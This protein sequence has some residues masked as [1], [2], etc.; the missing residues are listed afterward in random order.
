VITRLTSADVFPPGTYP[1][2]GGG[3]VL[4]RDGAPHSHDFI[5]LAIVLG[6]SAIHVTDGRQTE[7]GAGSIVAVRPGGW[8]GYRV[9]DTITVF[10]VYLTP[11]LVR[12]DL[13]WLLDF[14]DLARLLLQ[15]GETAARL[16][17]DRL[18]RAERWLT[19][20]GKHSAPHG[21]AD[22]LV[23][24]GLLECVL[25]EIGSVCEAPGERV[26]ISPAVRTV[27]E[28]M[29]SD[30]SRGWRVSELAQQACVSVSGLY[31]RFATDLGVSPLSFQTSLRAER[32]AV[33]L[34][35]TDL[36]V[37]AIGRQVGWPDA[38]YAGRRFRSVYGVSPRHYRA[39]FRAVQ[40]DD[41]TADPAPRH[42]GRG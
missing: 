42:D 7:L 20:I 31:R 36:T 33:L 12:R 24:R 22:S 4:T 14:P 16:P 17:D 15:G 8:H 28:V 1:I 39:R 11:E 23:A 13:P 21:S 10:N 26:G 37:T 29:T 18:A 27:I 38:N 41:A 6:G 35:Q 19:E 25:G 3:H 34:I 5:E 32:A 9:R 30:L 40:G 2:A